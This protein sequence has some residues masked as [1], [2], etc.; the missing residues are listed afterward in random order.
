M[1]TVWD[2]DKPPILPLVGKI[3]E[4]TRALYSKQLPFAGNGVERF[5]SLYGFLLHHL[6]TPLPQLRRMIVSKGAPIFSESQLASIVDTVRS[7]RGSAVAQRFT[8]LGAPP[9]LFA[10]QGGAAAVMMH[11]VTAA[12]VGAAVTGPVKLDADPSRSK[13]WDVFL[14]KRLYSVSKDIPP[15]FDGFAPI[16]FVLYGLEQIELLGP[17]LSTFLDTITL[18]L[19]TLAEMM[20]VGVSTFVALAPIP[21]A[22]F[23]GDIVAWFICF[24]FIMIS[25]TMSV[26]RKQFGTAFTISLGAVPLVGEQVS[27]AALLFEKGVERYDFNKHRVVE[28]VGKVSPHMAEFIDYWAP[29]TETKTGPPVVFD[30]DQF[31]LDLFKKAVDTQGEDTAMAMVRHPSALPASAQNLVSP[32]YKPL[33]GTKKGGRRRTRKV[34]R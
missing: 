2:Y 23:V 5:F 18:G 6:D 16:F 22:S 7:Q 15:A 34:Q 25:A 9:S 33:I 26:S 19:P 12:G 24:I 27:D 3:G 1:P 28:S 13:F 21:Y 14:R 11:P 20:S 8:R 31:M 30:S 29:T 17:L 10:Q 4:Y 32:K